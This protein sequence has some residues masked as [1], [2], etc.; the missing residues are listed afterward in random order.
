MSRYLKYLSNYKDVSCP[1]R[2]TRKRRCASLSMKKDK[3]KINIFVA[4]DILTRGL[5]VLFNIVFDNR[6]DCLSLFSYIGRDSII[7]VLNRMYVSI[8]FCFQTND[9]YQ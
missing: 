4:L 7:D 6:M 5:S 1:R 3:M 2:C 9:R 8:S